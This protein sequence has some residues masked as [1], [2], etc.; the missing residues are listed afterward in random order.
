M[1]AYA[2]FYRILTRLTRVSGLWFFS[3]I[4]GGI[5]VGYFLLFPKRVAVGI[6]FYQ[7]LFPEKSRAYHRWCT[8]RQFLDFTHVFRDRMLLA[9]SGGGITTTFDGWERLRD[10]MAGSGGILL[11]SH[12]GNWE[13]AARLLKKTLPDLKLLLY[14]GVKQKEQIEGMQKRA[15]RQSDIR[16]V[17][18]D[19]DGGSPFDIVDGIR[20]LRAGGLVSLT[21]DRVWQGEQ[22]TI[23]VR[24]LGQTVH[25]PAAPYVLA[26]VADSPIFVFF[27][28]RIQK[29]HYRFCASTPIIVQATERRQRES[30]MARA[31]QQ[32][33]DLL[34]DAV[35]RYPFQW[36]H[37]E[38]FLDAERQ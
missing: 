23:P 20:F 38:P 10:A 9:E 30:A 17:G 1:N 32:Y 36:H 29:C 37:F 25:L 6:R 35:R 31:A 27:A 7:A 15:V 26:M 11:M 34:E 5:A 8:F 19:A 28:V 2:L 13:V 18:V 4:S 24:F 33:A 12:M 21:G 16:I 22:R 3:L 14:M